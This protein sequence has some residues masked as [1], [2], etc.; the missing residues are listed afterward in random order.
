MPGGAF[1]STSGGRGFIPF[2][3]GGLTT[4]S[5]ATTGNSSHLYAASYGSGIYVTPLSAPTPTPEPLPPAPVLILPKSDDIVPQPYNGW[6]FEWQSVPGAQS[7]QIY[8][9][10]ARTTN[11]AVNAKTIATHYRQIREGAYVLAGNLADLTWKVRAQNGDGI[12]GPWS[13][14]RT[15]SIAPQ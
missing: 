4:C 12:W 11:P 7:Y 9:I 5:L 15:F 2:G 10:N 13:E 6:I 14:M 1:I 3:L 8:A